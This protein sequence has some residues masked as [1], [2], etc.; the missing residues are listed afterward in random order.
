MPSSSNTTIGAWLVAH[1][2]IGDVT[3]ATQVELY[4]ELAHLVLAAKRTVGELKNFG[5]DD[6]KAF[7]EPIEEVEEVVAGRSP[8]HSTH[9]FKSQISAETMKGLEFY[10]RILN[11]A[12]PEPT[13]DADK[14]QELLGEVQS[15][16]SDIFASDLDATLKAILLD[17]LNAVVRAI[18]LYAISGSAGLQRAAAAL[19]GGSLFAWLGSPDENS[20]PWIQRCATLGLRI[21]NVTGFMSNAATVLQAVQGEMPVLSN[22]LH[23]AVSH[24][25][26]LP[27]QLP[28]AS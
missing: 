21:V 23:H 4:A 26:S 8:Q 25:S 28:P 17:H 27:L 19:E 18:Q 20:K 13:L 9:Q 16:I 5:P 11:S 6:L 15:L 14:L 22:F 24:F 10:S 1:F 7:S 12:V 3:T 2:G